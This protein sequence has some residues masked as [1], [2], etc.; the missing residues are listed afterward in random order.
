MLKRALAARPGRV[1]GASPTSA[2]VLKLDRRHL[3]R[4]GQPLGR[5][6]TVA[7]T[8][9]LN[10]WWYSRNTAPN[11]RIIVRDHTG[12]PLDLLGGT[13][14]RGQPGR[15]HRALAGPE[16]RPH[17]RAARRRPPAVRRHAPRRR[18]QFLLWEYYDVPDRPRLVPPRRLR[19][20]PGAHRPAH[21]ARLPPHRPA[22]LRHGG[23]RRAGRVHRAGLARAAWSARSGRPSPW[24]V[25]RA[26]PGAG[27]WKGAALNGFM[28]TLLNLEAAGAVPHLAAR[29]AAPRPRR[30]A[31]PAARAGRREGR[32][33]GQGHRRERRADPRALP[34]PARHRVVEPLRPLHPGLGVAHPRRRPRATTATTSPCSSSSTARRRATASGA[35]RQRWDGYARRQGLNCKLKAP[36]W[37][38]PRPDR[39]PEAILNPPKPEPEPGGEAPGTTTTPGTTTAP[40]PRA[41]A[42]AADDPAASGRGPDHG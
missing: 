37:L 38:E 13:R 10:A 36:R 40:R 28:V 20:G 39:P 16:R 22:A 21:G 34:A 1:A 27:P 24:Y 3:L 31:D 5:R 6:S 4:R 18:A 33:G 15:D 32:R 29:A 8:L 12:R 25:E 14:A 9:R 19:H 2:W 30:A 11:S 42:D 23:R 7:R 17:A 26:Y 41:H 35:G